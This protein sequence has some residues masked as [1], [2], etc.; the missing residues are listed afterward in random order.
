MRRI[1]ML[2]LLLAVAGGA[3]AGCDDANEAPKTMPANPDMPMPSVD[4]S[5]M[6]AVVDMAEPTK[7]A[8]MNMMQRAKFMK[9]VVMPTMKPLFVAH[10]PV[11]FA[12]FDCTTCH[13]ANAVAHNFNMP[14]GELPLDFSKVRGD[15]KKMALSQF[16]QK[17]VVPTM[18]KLLQETEF[19]PKT[20]TGFGCSGCHTMVGGFG[21]GDGG[22]GRRDGGMMM[23]MH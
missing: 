5:D 15:T 19:D 18:V 3:V 21:G 22:M 1:G 2:C 10:D 8:D 13:G 7:Y 14:S 20:M 9:T 23:D 12:N 17:T 16:M 4:K 6:A 11:R